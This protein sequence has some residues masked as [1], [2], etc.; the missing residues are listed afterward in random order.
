MPMIP[1]TRRR[2]MQTSAALAATAVARP[3]AAWSAAA[4]DT[5]RMRQPHEFANADPANPVTRSDINIHLAIYSGLIRYLPSDKWEWGYD[6][7]EEM[8]QIDPTRIGFRLR[9]GIQWTNGFGE[10]TAEDVKFSFERVINPKLAS[11]YALELYP[12]D[13]VEVADKYNG[14]LVLEEPSAALWAYLPWATASILCKAAVEKDYAEKF[15]GTDPVA[16]SGAYTI[17]EWIPKQK[18]ILQANPAFYGTKPDFTTVEILPIT[19]DKSAEIAFEAGE[20][21]FTEIATSSLPR[22][23]EKPPVGAKIEALPALGARW[24]GMNTEA[25]PFDDARVRLAVHYA[26]DANEI[27]Q[28]AYYGLAPRATGIVPPG[29]LGHREKNNIAGPDRAKAKQL[30][31]EAGY[32]NGLKAVVTIEN[33]TDML[34]IAQLLQ[35][36]LAEVGIELEINPL[37]SGQF[38]IQGMESEGEYWKTLQMTINNW[39]WAPEP[40]GTTMWF[41]PEQVGVW[42]WER[43]NSPEFGELHKKALQELDAE[44]RAQM[45][46]RMQDLME[47]SG[48]YLMLTP[49]I[50]P[51]LFRDTIVPGHSPDG[52][53]LMLQHFR[54]A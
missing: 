6:A 38:W 43:W 20:I 46:V 3:R 53:R 15:I 35:G 10:M 30:L 32:P 5:L 54:R 36:Q 14:V 23:I 44:K 49:G 9:Q 50:N 17:K 22:Y 52:R 27:L 25:D 48:A 26:V 42:N 13:H 8:K 18:L 28:G 37:D 31:T 41:V 51:L 12:L 45:Y 4:G 33:N 47:E 19:D 7:A 40:S 1:M 39:G 11:G 24:I 29:L 21:D 34:T 16:T 2:L